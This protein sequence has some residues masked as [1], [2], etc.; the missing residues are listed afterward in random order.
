MGN[1]HDPKSMVILS[2]TIW[3]L[4]HVTRPNLRLYWA[5]LRTLSKAYSGASGPDQGHHRKV[6]ISLSTYNCEDWI[7]ET[8]TS[9]VG[10]THSNWVLIVHDDAS[11]DL[12]PEIVKVMAV[13]DARIKFFV[14]DSNR[15]AYRNH[16]S[17]RKIALEQE[18]ADYFTII[19]HDDIAHPSWL[20]RNV[21][22]INN[23]KAIGVRPINIRVDEFN[24]AELYSYPAVNQTFWKIEI[25]EALGGY[26]T[27]IGIPD[28]EFMMRAERFCILTGE[29]ICL[30]LK[31]N[32]RM[33]V[34][35]R[36]ESSRYTKKMKQELE[37][38][39]Y[40]NAAMDKLCLPL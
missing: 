29:W 8:I 30:S 6:V 36:N 24:K 3:R 12:T 33:R 28:T 11:N 39:D 9:I 35:E 32:H 20:T 5:T 22:I 14:N 27:E 4:L 13:S 19:D 17:A 26:N 40:A 37:V 15:G 1:I 34:H 38:I 31:D 10:Q 18:N 7:E 23:S 21:Q 16:N 2:K 25:I